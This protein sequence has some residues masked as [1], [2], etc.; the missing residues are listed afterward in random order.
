MVK[1]T[2]KNPR[3]QTRI[4]ED[5]NSFCPPPNQ[6]MQT[7][8][9]QRT[10]SSYWICG[11]FA[12][13]RSSDGR[14][15]RE[16]AFAGK[17]LLSK[18]FVEDYGGAVSQVQRSG[19]GM[20]HRNADP[21]VRVLRKQLWR[22]AGGF[23]AK[24]EKVFGGVL[25]F[26]VVFGPCGFDEPKPSP[27]AL[28]CVKGLPVVPSMPRNLLPIIHSSA[29]QAFVVHLESERFD[30]VKRGFCRRAESGDI[31][32]VGR[33]FGFDQDDAHWADYQASA[34]SKRIKKSSPSRFGQACTI[35]GLPRFFH[36]IQ[37]SSGSS[38]FRGCQAKRRQ[39]IALD[40]KRNG[41]RRALCR[42]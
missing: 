16:G 9:P 41:R 36:R 33:N 34:F 21:A 12:S 10:Y 20:E 2:K 40:A 23:S 37:N 28:G 42:Y 4:C 22:Q 27:S 17:A 39:Y 6:K 13:S 38:I 30:E 8:F 1:L 19:G 31:P 35:L 24:E 11:Q 25:D 3:R 32:S 7:D 15:R 29:L 26:G 18:R 5:S 14:S